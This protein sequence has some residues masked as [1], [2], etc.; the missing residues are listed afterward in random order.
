MTYNEKIRILMERCGIT[1]DMAAQL[2][3]SSGG[4]LLDAMALFSK[5]QAPGGQGSAKALE[6]GRNAVDKKPGDADSAGEFFSAL[7]KGICYVMKSLVY[8]SLVFTKGKKS[9]KMPLIIVVLLFLGGNFIT[10]IAFIFA[11][12]SGYE[13]DVE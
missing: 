9:V 7:W 8:R 3:S 1:Y 11:I 6:S 12:I 4:D 2:L 5:Q 13:L 10:A